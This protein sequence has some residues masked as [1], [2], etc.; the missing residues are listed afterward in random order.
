MATYQS[1]VMAGGGNQGAKSGPYPQRVR[2]ALTLLSGTQLSSGASDVMQ[3]FKVAA[4][5]RLYQLTFDSQ[6]LDGGAALVADLRDNVSPTPNTYLAGG[7]AMTVN[8]AASTLQALLRTG[9]FASFMTAANVNARFGAVLYTVDATIQLV[10][11]TGAA[12][13]IGADRVLRFWADVMAD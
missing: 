7:S 10:V 4:G 11:T 6:A 5:C 3:L 13:A 9:G 2:G 12:S 8:G 1:D